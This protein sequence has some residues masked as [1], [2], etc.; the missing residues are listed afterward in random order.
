MLTNLKVCFWRT[1][2]EP[3]YCRLDTS[4]RLV[5]KVTILSAFKSQWTRWWYKVHTMNGTFISWHLRLRFV[6][7]LSKTFV[8]T[9]EN[10]ILG[11]AF[12]NFRIR[13]F[14]VHVISCSTPND[15]V[16][17]VYVARY[18]L[19]GR[20]VPIIHSNNIFSSTFWVPLISKMLSFCWF[21]QLVRW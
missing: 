1:L 11:V 12:L 2:C 16:T 14:Q 19:V 3:R 7:H 18:N 8:I 4:D 5:T 10:S 13:Q 21:D 6:V 9:V 15:T 20:T 17:S